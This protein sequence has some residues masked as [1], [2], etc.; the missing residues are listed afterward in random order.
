M[1]AITWRQATKDDIGRLARFADRIG[2]DWTYG[3]FS[4]LD[5]EEGFYHCLDIDGYS[6]EWFFFCEVQDVARRAIHPDV[7][8]IESREDFIAR[9]VDCCIDNLLNESLY[10]SMPDSEPVTLKEVL[11]AIQDK[12]FL[13]AYEQGRLELHAEQ[14]RDN[15]I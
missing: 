7:P 3:L 15:C 8:N 13:V 10:W 1:A 12:L 14:V 11:A 6:P 9:E 5:A 4:G 2:D